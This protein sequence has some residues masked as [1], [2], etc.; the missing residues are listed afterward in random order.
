[1]YFTNESNGIF[2][3]IIIY[4]AIKAFADLTSK[5][6]NSKKIQVILID[7]SEKKRDIKSNEHNNN[8]NNKKNITSNDYSVKV[9]N[10]G[11]Q[12]TKEEINRIFSIF[13][14]IK[15]ITNPKEY[16]HVRYVIIIYKSKEAGIIV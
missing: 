13:G 10:I 4:I 3:I 1:M 7:N 2:I 12:I 6:Y 11:N 15:Q 5:K 8:N 9:T 14:D 16:N